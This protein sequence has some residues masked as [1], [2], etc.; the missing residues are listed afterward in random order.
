LTAAI[1]FVL[2]VFKVI[3]NQKFRKDQN[4]FLPIAPT[5]NAT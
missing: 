4:V 1:K 5:Q 3:L 2:I